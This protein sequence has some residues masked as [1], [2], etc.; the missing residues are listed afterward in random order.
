MLLQRFLR[1]S[2]ASFTFR[3]I[4]FLTIFFMPRVGH[5]DEPVFTHLVSGETAIFAGY[6]LSPEAVGTLVSSD[7]ETRLKALAEQELKFDEERADLSRQI[8]E[9][10]ARIERLSGEA[11][12]VSDAREKE[13]QIYLAE[14]GML[15]RRAIIWCAAG[16]AAGAG[17]AVVATSL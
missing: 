5:C 16:A 17:I 12:V 10:D 8:K 13:R 9:R 4:F 14:I 2:T 11:K 7:D 3:S 6:L 1:T 15:R